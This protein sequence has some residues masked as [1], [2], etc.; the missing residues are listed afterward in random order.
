MSYAIGQRTR[1]LGLRMALGATPR[2]IAWLVLGR[3]S[4]HVIAGLALGLLL[5]V[6]F[7][8][9]F[10]DT[11]APDGPT[12]PSLL[13]PLAAIVALVCVAACLPVL[14]RALRLDPAS[15]LRFE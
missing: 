7:H 14:R 6:A 5:T 8:A 15:T 3:L 13:I 2:R 1:E 12:S 9:R 4:G 11:S 10:S